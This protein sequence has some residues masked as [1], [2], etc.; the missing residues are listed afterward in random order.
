M[1]NKIYKYQF[2]LAAK[3]IEISVS[4]AVIKISSDTSGV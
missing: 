4:D 3:K 1:I 2:I